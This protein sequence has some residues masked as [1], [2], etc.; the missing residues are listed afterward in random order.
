ML[1]NSIVLVFALAVMIKAG[2]ALFA[3]GAQ[4]DSVFTIGNKDGGKQETTLGDLTTDAM[5]TALKTDIA[6]LAAS[7]LKVLEPPV[8]AQ[9]IQ[10]PVLITTISFPDDPL[11]VL[12]LTGKQVKAALE[13][14]VSL[15][16]QRNLGFLQVAGIKFTFDPKKPN[17]KRVSAVVVGKEPLDDNRTYTVAVTNSMANGALGYWNVWKAENIVKRVPEQSLKKALNS[18]LGTSPKLQYKVPSRVML[19]EP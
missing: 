18:Y 13:R 16:P 4:P 19:P 6:F 9:N 2:V 12:Q 1:R 8:P 11:A 3:Q 15:Y 7:E 14:G 17:G 5:R 10:P